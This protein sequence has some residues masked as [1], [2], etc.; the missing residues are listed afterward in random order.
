[1]MI[2]WGMHD[3]VEVGENNMKSRKQINKYTTYTDKQ[4]H[5]HTHTP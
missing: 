2:M 1:M 3:D 4:T 5:T